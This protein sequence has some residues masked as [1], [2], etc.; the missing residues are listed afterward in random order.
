MP[1]ILCVDDENIQ[2]TLL[3]F[4][5]TGAGFNVIL[6]EDG[7]DA[8]DLAI[9]HKPDIILMDLM[10]PNKD[11]IE[12]TR[13]IK[14]NVDLVHIPIVSYTAVEKGNLTK[15]VLEA[16]ATKIIHKT[17]SPSDLVRQVKELLP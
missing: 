2:R 16:G 11:G 9:E 1:T 15:A 4:A 8:V 17:T 3:K 12:A 6:A 14:A 10:M 7:Q 13:E 5:F